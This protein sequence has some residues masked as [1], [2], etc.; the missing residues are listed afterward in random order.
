MLHLKL[1]LYK[2]H[3]YSLAGRPTLI[4]TLLQAARQITNHEWLH[5]AVETSSPRAPVSCGV[6]LHPAAT[7]V[8]RIFSG[9]PVAGFL[10]ETR[11]VVISC[12]QLPP[13]LL[14]FSF[15]Q[16]PEQTSS[17]MATTTFPSGWS[18]SS[19][20]FSTWKG[21]TVWGCRPSSCSSSTIE[22]MRGCTSWSKPFGFPRLG[23][24]R[25]YAAEVQKVTKNKIA[26]IDMVMI[27]RTG[28]NLSCNWVRSCDEF[29]FR[30]H[31]LYMRIKDVIW[32]MW[33]DEKTPHV[34]STV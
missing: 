22:T 1:Y 16:A 24:I 8:E 9:R 17:L 11:R 6:Q 18:F 5:H 2:F 26:C 31:R 14:Q 32:K 23:M 13:V 21:Q 15:L 7:L 10:M 12:L 4:N 30:F 19:V 25:Q 27:E 33:K 3:S 29:S 20:F 34:F 28:S